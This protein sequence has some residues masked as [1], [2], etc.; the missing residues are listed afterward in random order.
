M[1]SIF[2]SIKIITIFIT[3]FFVITGCGDENKNKPSA[4]STQSKGT[5][6][7]SVDE[8]FQPV[9]SEQIKVY[10]SDRP[11]VKIIAEYKSEADCFRDLQNDSTRMVIVGRGLTQEE[12]E[13][14]KNNL[15]YYP[16][17]FLLA[18]DAVSVIMN[19]R[20]S[21]ST[22]T[23]ESLNAMVTTTSN[24]D[25]ALVVDGLNATSTV[26]YIQD[27]I[28][29]G[30]ALGPHVQGVQGSKA[31][32]DYVANNVNAI[33][34]VGSSWVGNEY[35]PEQVAYFGKVKQALIENV[36]DS[37]GRF[38]KPSQATI[39][40]DLYP[41]I[42]PIWA[43]IKENSTQL[44]SGFLGFMRGERGQLI[45]RRANLVPAE[46][47]FGVRQITVGNNNRDSTDKNNRK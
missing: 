29:K 16:K 37:L 10:E 7:I 14:Y 31:V 1:N 36:H 34:F 41:F 47:Y 42:R 12:F 38:V 25:K 43:I 2:R 46:M 11:E 26:L 33:G 17:N 21:D 15:G 8:T 13:G 39:S 20:S 30:K 22:L 19:A 35:D 27:S 28:A 24:I 45:F 6:Y 9:I 44:G 32:I 18:W 5:I 3:L 4:Y 40:T 23:M